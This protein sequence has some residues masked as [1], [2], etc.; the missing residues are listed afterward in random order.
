VRSGS[1]RGS[2]RRDGVRLGLFWSQS[3][4][5]RMRS[6]LFWAP[7]GCDRTRSGSAFEVRRTTGCQAPPW[8]VRPTTECCDRDELGVTPALCV[9]AIAGSG[10]STNQIRRAYLVATGAGAPEGLAMSG[11]GAR[12]GR[13]RYEDVSPARSCSSFHLACV[14]V[15]GQCMHDHDRPLRRH[16]RNR[17]AEHVGPPIAPRA[18]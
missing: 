16:G 17:A 2:R 7:R 4:S 8:Q 15:C 14:R 18:G 1:V 12:C 6:D 5:D 3:G 9:I 11:A 10:H 13:H